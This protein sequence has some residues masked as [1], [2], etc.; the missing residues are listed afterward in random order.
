MVEVFFDRRYLEV[1]FTAW[2]GHGG[3]MAAKI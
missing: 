3:G 1:F 2:E